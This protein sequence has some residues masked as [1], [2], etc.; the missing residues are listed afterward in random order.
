VTVE[1]QGINVSNSEGNS[2]PQ[3]A[4]AAGSHQAS[5]KAAVAEAGLESHLSREVTRLAAELFIGTLQFKLPF[6]I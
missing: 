2:M 6:P 5:I 1:C 4:L 3:Q